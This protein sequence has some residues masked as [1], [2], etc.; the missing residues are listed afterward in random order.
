VA[1]DEIAEM[2]PSPQCQIQ[3]VASLMYSNVFLRLICVHLWCSHL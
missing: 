3:T 2:L 1:D